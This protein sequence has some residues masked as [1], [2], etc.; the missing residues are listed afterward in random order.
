VSPRPQGGT[1]WAKG[2]VFPH[3]SR[4][5]YNDGCSC[6]PCCGANASY[7]QE[8]RARRKAAGNPVPR[9]A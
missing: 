2:A 8:Y 1:G 6:T 5:R 7:M 3:G 9:G 4:G